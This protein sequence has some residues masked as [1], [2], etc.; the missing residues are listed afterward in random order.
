MFH[1]T[2]AC[3]ALIITSLAL[4]LTACKNPEIRETA[5]VPMTLINPDASAQTNALYRNLARVGQ[6]HLLFGHQNTTAYGVSCRGDENRSDVKDIVGSYPAVFGWD[7]GDLERGDEKN[8]D[9]IRFDF[10]VDQ[11]KNTYRRGGISTLSWHMLNPVS[12]GDSW[13]TSRAVGD[14]IPGGKSHQQLKDNL[15]AFIAFNQQPT[16]TDEQGQLQAIPI[17]FRPWHEHNGDW[18]WWGTKETREQDYIALWRFTVDYLINEHKQN[19]LIFAFSSDRGRNNLDEPESYLYGY[20]G[21]Q[22][23]DI[24]GLDN[25]WD[26]GHSGNKAPI[27]QRKADFIRSLELIANIAQKKH[28]IAALSEGGQETVPEDTFWTDMVLD[29]FASN[30]QTQSIAY[31][32][33]WRNANKARENTDHFYAPYSGHSSAKNFIKFYGSEF[34]LFEDQLPD[35]YH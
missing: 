16:F 7:L 27:A 2:I 34:T 20:P 18:F 6:N 24:I 19:N 17:I 33:V 32:L 28:K 29:S 31:F 9:S 22:Y 15:D 14:V 10:V 3:T 26:L 5:A 30:K 35:M 12:G 25:Y 1:R 8:L 4:T 13:D 21:D 23:V 11:I